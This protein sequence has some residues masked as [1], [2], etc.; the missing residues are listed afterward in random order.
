MD[1]HHADL[2]EFE[3][4]RLG[5]LRV[6]DAIDDLHFE[7]VVARAEGAALLAAAL[8]G[9]RGDFVRV[10][11]VDTAVG[12]GVIQVLQLTE[13]AVDHEARPLAEDAL[14]LGNVELVLP[15]ADRPRRGQC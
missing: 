14:G 10:G 2:V 4:E 6:G 11:P 1:P 8:D 15:G 13:V 12:L 3:A 7:E 9:V 5:N